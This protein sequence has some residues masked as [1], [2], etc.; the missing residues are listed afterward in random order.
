MSS[1][2]NSNAEDQLTKSKS[3]GMISSIVDAVGRMLSGEYDD[4]QQHGP[5]Q[6]AISMDEQEE[7]EDGCVS[8]WIPQ[9]IPAKLEANPDMPA[10]VAFMVRPVL[11]Q[12]SD[13]SMIAGR[14]FIETYD[15]MRTDLTLFELLNIDRF[16]VLGTGVMIDIRVRTCAESHDVDHCFNNYVFHY[17]V[18][19][20][21][22]WS[23]APTTASP[24]VSIDVVFHI[25]SVE[26]MLIYRHESKRNKDLYTQGQFYF[27]DVLALFEPH[28]RGDG[29]PRD[30][31]NSPSLHSIDVPDTA[32]QAPEAC[33]MGSTDEDQDSDVQEPRKRTRSRSAFEE[34]PKAL[35]ADGDG[36]TAVALEVP[37]K[38]PRLD[39]N[40]ND[41]DA[42]GDDNEEGE[43]EEK[44][45]QDA[46]V[47]ESKNA[48]TTRKAKRRA[49]AVKVR[50]SDKV[51]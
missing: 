41:G 43:G 50:K 3:K 2:S 48:K 38:R 42:D 12:A 49:R 39:Q 27:A 20:V 14:P 11:R 25:S 19:A 18:E 36:S 31:I 34:R 13:G 26:D 45:Q 29:L 10:F 1:D 30:D 24:V 16:D 40:D 21:R 15:T 44:Q 35:V 46:K 47:T 5:P 4:F 28:S 33:H 17:A 23:S 6:D 9:S 51:V 37:A 7:K 32:S 22:L 8:S